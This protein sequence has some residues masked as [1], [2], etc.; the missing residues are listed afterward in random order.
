MSKYFVKSFQIDKSDTKHL[1][2]CTQDV[3]VKEIKPLSDVFYDEKFNSHRVTQDWIDSRIYFNHL[4]Y[5]II[6]KISSKCEW[7]KEG[8]E[9]DEENIIALDSGGSSIRRPISKI[10]WEYADLK[11]GSP[12]IYVKN[13]ET[14]VFPS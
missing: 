2:L 1:Y 9:F 8:D 7:V 12:K 5:K 14:N 3:N 11:N 4:W 13:P 10:R 6:G